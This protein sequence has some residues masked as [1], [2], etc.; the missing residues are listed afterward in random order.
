MCLWSLEA[1][2]EGDNEPFTFRRSGGKTSVLH[3]A[4]KD[5][6]AKLSQAAAATQRADR[7]RTVFNRLV[8]S[9]VVWVKRCEGCARGVCLRRRRFERRSVPW[10]RELG[11]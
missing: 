10:F 9:I 2:L 6:Q 11:G 5:W 3:P 8:W 7:A 4:A 1:A